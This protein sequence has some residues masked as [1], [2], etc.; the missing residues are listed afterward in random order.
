MSVAG[1]LMWTGL[2][3]STLPDRY[4]W[5]AEHKSDMANRRN[6]R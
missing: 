1:K 2:H 6:Y 5:N 3:G 4:L